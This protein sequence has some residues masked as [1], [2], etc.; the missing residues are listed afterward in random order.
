[1]NSLPEGCRVL[2]S[3]EYLDM[4][5]LENPY[6]DGGAAELILDNMH[7]TVA[8]QYALPIKLF[9]YMSAGIPVIASDF[10]LWRKIIDGAQCG[11]LVDPVQPKSIADAIDW[12]LDHPEDG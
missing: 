1:L 8:Y 10:P 5:M 2:E 3:V 7:P 12:L 11:L 6:G 9:E 4:V